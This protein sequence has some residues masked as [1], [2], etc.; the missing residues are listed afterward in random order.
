MCLIE[1]E[2]IASILKYAT[3]EWAPNPFADEIQLFVFWWSK[4]SAFDRKI[5]ET[6]RRR[7]YCDRKQTGK[8]SNMGLMES[9]ELKNANRL[10][11]IS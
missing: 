8:R 4:L 7:R 2:V 6:A 5:Q 9:K 1:R 3:D 10:G 11:D